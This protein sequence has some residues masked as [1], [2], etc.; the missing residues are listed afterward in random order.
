[1][2]TRMSPPG[3]EMSAWTADREKLSL[4]I[5]GKLL[6]VKHHFPRQGKPPTRAGTAITHLSRAS[7]LRCLK[8]LATIDWQTIGSSLFVTLTY[9]DELALP[10][11]EKRNRQRYLWHRDLERYLGQE[12]PCLWRS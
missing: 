5:H 2:N 8:I 12:I 3:K 9:P 6:T 1:M 11:R 4:T 10:D 7:R